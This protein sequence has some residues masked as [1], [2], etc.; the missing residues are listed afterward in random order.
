L[1]WD[2]LDVEKIGRLLDEGWRLKRQLASGIS[3]DVLDGWYGRAL[4]AGA[5]GGK[6]C[7]AGGGGFFLF[8]VPPVRRAKV[9]EAMQ[10]LQ[11][12]EFA[13]EPHGSHALLIA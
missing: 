9:R 6:L 5:F 3:S 11:E 7:G 13:Y 8:L 4:G 2:G 1:L 12:I 10:G